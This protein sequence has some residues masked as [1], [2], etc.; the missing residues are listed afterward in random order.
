MVAGVQPHMRASTANVFTGPVAAIADVLF[1]YRIAAG[2]RTSTRLLITKMSLR[3]AACLLL[4]AARAEG[5][6]S[7]GEQRVC[8]ARNADCFRVLRVC[9][10]VAPAAGRHACDVLRLD[11]S[12]GA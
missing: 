6:W 1:E 10:C 8:H 7:G 12:V 11:R 9:F 2:T 3:T 5:V 4:N